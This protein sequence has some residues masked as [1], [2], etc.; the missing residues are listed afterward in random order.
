MVRLLELLVSL[1]IVAVLILVIGVLLPDRGHVERSV[2]VS[3]PV[4]QIY[5]SINTLHRFPDWSPERR[6]DPALSFDYAGPRDGVG[7]ALTYRGN[8]LVGSGRLE[9][10]ESDTDSQVRMAVENNFAGKNKSY[11]IRLDPAQNGKTTRIYWRYDAE[12]GWNL[13]WRYAGLYIHG[14][15]DANVQTAVGSLSNMLATFP[16]VDYKD[17][18]I[19]VVDVVGSPMIY[20]SLKAP[21][22][23]DDV[24]TATDEATAK[25]E[26]FMKKAGLA[27]S[28]PRRT[29]TT[30][31]G[32]ESYVFD[33]AIPV[34]STTFT[35]DRKE[36]TIPAAPAMNGN[37]DVLEG[38]DDSDEPRT[39]AVGDIDDNGHLILEDGIKATTSYTGKA[40][41][42][43][44]DGSAAS[45]PLLRV[46]EKAWAETHGYEY[47]EMDNGRFWDE[48]VPPTPNEDGSMPAAE[49]GVNT[50]RVYLPVME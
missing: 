16:N 25:L 20:V 29:I 15:P 50:W 11:T 30:N 35:F 17:Q 21:R 37:D 27:A 1:V 18:N 32:D 34:N 14:A 6:L 39:Y 42:S 31:W 2:E 9:I 45:I 19:E 10:I 40:L 8:D 24:A 3:N 36:F 48:I 33:V 28:G 47:S 26:A 13:F 4:R 7:A 46:M 12:Y 38:L 23:L 22:T 5:D 49:E 44:Y 43:Q 41:A